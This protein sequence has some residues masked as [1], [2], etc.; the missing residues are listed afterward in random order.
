MHEPKL[1]AAIDGEERGP[2]RLAPTFHRSVTVQA[3][4]ARRLFFATAA[5]L[6]YLPKPRHL[7]LTRRRLLV[8]LIAMRAFRAI[9]TAAIR[10][11]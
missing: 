3:Q 8:L 5:G 1:T 11:W 2:R 9:T 10:P 4:T 7:G 6:G